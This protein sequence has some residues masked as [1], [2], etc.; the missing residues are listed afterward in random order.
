MVQDA[1]LTKSIKDFLI[2]QGAKL[3]G[4]ADMSEVE[5]CPFR[6]GISVALP[7]PATI[8]K[9]VQEKPTPK[10]FQMYTDLN[11][12]LNEIVLAGEKYLR[13]R[14]YQAYALTTNRA[15]MVDSFTSTLPH[16]TPATRAGIGWIGKSCLLVTEE[17]GS[18]IRLSTLYTDAPLQADEPITGSKCGSCNICVNA[19]PAHAL[20]GTLWEL[21]T[22]RSEIA[23]MEKCLETMVAITKQSLGF[24][25]DICG[26]CFAVC[27]YTRKYLSR[28][29]SRF[30]AETVELNSAF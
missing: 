26:R 18:A 4:V 14:G 1:V 13:D 3:V 15:E 27:R 11:H 28:E 22:P 29:D 7:I 9:P 23:D 19:C 12:K 2:S 25:V 24:E 10:Y 16:K 8:V 5:T 21:G 17:Y 20:K 30:R 6:Y